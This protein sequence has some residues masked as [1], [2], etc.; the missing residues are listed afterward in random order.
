VSLGTSFSGEATTPNEAREDYTLNNW[1]FTR[2]FRSFI[3]LLDGQETWV[4]VRNSL[5]PKV[6]GRYHRLN[7][8]FTGDEP[9]LDAIKSMLD[10][11]K[12][13]S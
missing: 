4:K 11:E 10:L 12:Q 5:P 9:R 2:L 3:N 8:E 13:A 6:Q 1:S 7:I